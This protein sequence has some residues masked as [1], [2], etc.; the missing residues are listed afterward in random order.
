MCDGSFT[1]SNI[2]HGNDSRYLHCNV[3]LGNPDGPRTCRMADGCQDT[4]DDRPTTGRHVL[5]CRSEGGGKQLIMIDRTPSSPNDR[6]ASSQAQAGLLHGPQCMGWR[7]VKLGATAG[8]TSA[9]ALLR[10]THP[11]T[12][13]ARLSAL[14]PKRNT[15]PMMGFAH[16]SRALVHTVRRPTT[17]ICCSRS[18]DIIVDHFMCV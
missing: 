18:R 17:S 11:P 15:W 10:S 2:G 3:G 5:R 16:S 4:V 12:P 8:S 14:E 9:H 1:V 13:A 6:H 7:M